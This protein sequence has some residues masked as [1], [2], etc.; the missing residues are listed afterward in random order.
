MLEDV[1]N[2]G[3]WTYAS[4]E[5]I[6]NLPRAIVARQ[7]VGQN[8][9]DWGWMVRRGPVQAIQH[10]CQQMSWHALHQRGSVMLHLH[11]ASVVASTAVCWRRGKIQER[12]GEAKYLTARQSGT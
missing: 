10:K 2:P 1:P 11:D 7:L 6:E 12:L 9:S 4:L 5:K 3:I 8:V